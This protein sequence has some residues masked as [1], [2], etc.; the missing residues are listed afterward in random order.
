MSEKDKEEFRNAVREIAHLC[1]RLESPYD[2]VRCCE[3]VRKLVAIEDDNF[4]MAKI[5]NE[6]IQLLRV[7]VRH[8]Y[9]RTPFVLP[10]PECEISSL[11]ECV[12]NDLAK[13]SPIFPNTGP[14]API[15][16]HSSPDGRAY[17]SAKRIPGGGVFCYMAV[18]PDGFA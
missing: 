2:R 15:I 1:V 4:E 5:R 8:G 17:I 13:R 6:Y 9:L 3:W 10:P 16:M 11:A 7:M 18:T 14:I 12:A